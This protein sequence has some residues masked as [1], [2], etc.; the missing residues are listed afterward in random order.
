MDNIAYL[1]LGSN[2]GNK[3]EN[4]N[5]SIEE[6]SAKAGKIINKSSVYE[7]QAWGF[8]TDDL[9][10]NQVIMIGT[11]LTPKVL[12]VTVLDIEKQ[13]GRKQKTTT[14]YESRL[15]DIDILFYNSEII[16]EI[17]LVIPHPHLHKR[18][19][20]LFPL[21]EIAGNYIHPVFKKNILD[22]LQESVDDC[23]VLK[24]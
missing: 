16:N 2:L 14:D 5:K 23:E 22:L 15:I 8:E 21:K 17:D 1:L 18:N 4:L 20:T 3:R 10:V 12:L 11:N 24:V 19:F 7:T 13:I 9:F 6:I